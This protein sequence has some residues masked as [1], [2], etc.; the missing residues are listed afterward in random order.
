MDTA[1]PNDIRHQSNKMQHRSRIGSHCTDF[2]PPPPQIMIEL[3]SSIALKM[4][5][6]QSEYAKPSGLYN[7]NYCID[8][9]FGD[10]L[11]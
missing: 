4:F 2:P 6:N 10:Q 9:Y 1:S 8:L 11:M 5:V 7:Y 3:S